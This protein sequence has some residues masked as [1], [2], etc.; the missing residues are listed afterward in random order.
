VANYEV[1]YDEF[2]D[3]WLRDNQEWL[4]ARRDL[5]GKVRK[6]IED[7]FGAGFNDGNHKEQL[8]QYFI[9]GRRIRYEGKLIRDFIQG[10]ERLLCVPWESEEQLEKVFNYRNH[11][12]IER[13]EMAH[14]FPLLMSY[15]YKG[16]K[17][18]WPRIEL[19]C[20][21]VYGDKYTE[22]L[23]PN[24]PQLKDLC[25]ISPTP[26]KTVERFLS[27]SCD[28]LLDE[29]SNDTFTWQICSFKYFKSC[30]DFL[31][32]NDCELSNRKLRSVE[33][34]FAAVRNKSDSLGFYQK[35]LYVCLSSY[36][37]SDEVSNSLICLRA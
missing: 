24:L 30:V 35:K 34:R 2:E 15:Y 32:D 6:N 4:E 11:V 29:K 9:Y 10:I 1:Y 12:A 20:D 8:T 22:K 16:I 5:W 18:Q 13:V 23:S 26:K 28:F 25:V 17:D 7:Y 21:F 37:E 33:R 3:L 36:F 19:F 14:S 31:E 27:S